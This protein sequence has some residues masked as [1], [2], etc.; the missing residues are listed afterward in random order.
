MK[1]SL[2][3]IKAF[4]Q[5]SSRVSP[6]VERVL[7]LSQNRNSDLELGDIG[8]VVANLPN[9]YRAKFR[10]GDKDVL[11]YLHVKQ[12]FYL[13][14]RS[15]TYLEFVAFV[16]FVALRELGPTLPKVPPLSSPWRR[17]RVYLDHLVRLSA[18]VRYA[19]RYF[20][21]E[22]RERVERFVHKLASGPT[23][24]LERVRTLLGLSILF[25]YSLFL[26]IRGSEDY[27]IDLLS[28]IQSVDRLSVFFK[29]ALIES[30]P[31]FLERLKR[32]IGEESEPVRGLLDYLRKP[33]A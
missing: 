30:S 11:V 26:L 23:G 21:P 10:K 29:D 13:E 3:L 28:F 5:L 25:P 16:L 22:E 18:R 9:G 4:F 6:K 20:S 32:S 17:I 1:A 31:E 7:L 27:L 19:F 12:A 24:I 8:L 15:Y 14:P 2:S 33:E